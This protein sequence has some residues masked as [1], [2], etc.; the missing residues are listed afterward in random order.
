[1]SSSF[2]TALI[3]SLSGKEIQ[4]GTGGEPS[5]YTLSGTVKKGW[6]DGTVL[7]NFSYQMKKVE[8]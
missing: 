8:N 1:M 2:G 4:W 3:G 6:T 7:M 5:N